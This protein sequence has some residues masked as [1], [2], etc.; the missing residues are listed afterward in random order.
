MTPPRLSRLLLWLSA[1]ADERA[2]LVEEA[3]AEFTRLCAHD[4]VPAARAWYRR[5]ARQSLLPLLTERLRAAGTLQGA[6]VDVRHAVRNVM[7]HRG[8]SC[9]VVVTLGLASAAA[10]AALVVVDA[11]LLTPL[12]FPGS[13]RIVTVWNTGPR[14]PAA[15]RAVSFQDWEDWRAS[16]KTLTTLSAHTPVSATLTGRGDARRLNGIRVAEAFDRVLDVDAALGRFFVP[17]DF[18]RGADPAIVIS[19]DFWRREFGGDPSV[20]HATIALNDRPHRIVGVLPPMRTPFPTAPHDYWT[21]LFPREG[22]RWEAARNTGWI[23]VVGRLAPGVT[24]DVA[25]S[26]LSQIAARLAAAYPDSNADRPAV[27]VAPL[28]DEIVRHARPALLLT[29]AATTALLVVAFGNVLHLLFAQ[30]AARR[31]EL[32]VRH[33]LGASRGRLV[34]QAVYEA[35]SLAAGSLAG[36]L[37]LAPVMLRALDS[38]PASAIPRRLEIGL[39]PAGLVWGPLILAATTL[40][41]AWPMLRAPASSLTAGEASFRTTGSRGDRRARHVLVATQSGLSVALIIAGVLVAQTLHRLQAVHLGFSAERVLTLQPT[42]SPAVAPSADRT[43][44]FYR[45]AIAAIAGLPDVTGV[46]ASTSTPFVIGGWSYSVAAHDNPTGTRYPVQV[47]VASPTYFETLGASLVEGRWM[48]ED[49]H[50]GG[51]AVVINDRLATLLFGATSAVNRPFE[52]SNRTW[53]VVGVARGM[54]RRVAEPPIAMLYLPWS[55]AGQR[56]QAL[57]VRTAKDAPILAAVM[58]RLKGLDPNVTVTDSGLLADRISRT[59]QPERFRAGLLTGL[60]A[61]AGWLALLGVYSVT[62]F[63]VRSQRHELAIRLTLGETVPAARRRLVWS[64][65]GPAAAGVGL[66]L[67]AAWFASGFMTTFLFESSPADPRLLAVPA[68]LLALVAL[69][70]FVPA[71]RLA[72]LDPAAVLRSER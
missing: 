40:V 47:A 43:I 26:E 49:E 41:I 20:L 16:S 56:P 2:L 4:G 66:G 14:L 61:L 34:R 53:R 23:D 33:A 44:A 58:E 15:V 60:A 62:T 10:L 25:A 22:V 29:A 13:D 59:L 45:E 42:P 8:A 50:R 46:A 5:Q 1:P 68:L 9:T 17:D 51:D 39:W 12:A 67:V 3:D 38:L 11:V 63:A 19:H 28:Q 32:A 64:S 21:P 31:R 71:S 55:M 65:V 18:R 6:G 52:Y 7:R 37:M 27:A 24:V 36:G 35:A 72:G 69:A 48:T 70:A 54:R 30:V 57:L